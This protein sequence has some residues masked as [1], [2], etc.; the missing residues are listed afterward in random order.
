MRLP[1][2]LPAR[3]LTSTRRQLQQFSTSPPTPQPVRVYTPIR[4]TGDFHTA[5]RLSTTANAPLITLWTASYCPSCRTV[6]REL[7]KLFAERGGSAGSM[8]AKDLQYVEVELDA[9]GGGV[10]ELGVRYM[11]CHDGS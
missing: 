5:L 8:E 6:K 4:N 11:V 10:D 7:E 1:A 2:R 3:L 9:Q